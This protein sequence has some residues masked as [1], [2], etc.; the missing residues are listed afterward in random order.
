[1]DKI[2]RRWLAWQRVAYLV[3]NA[4]EW[5]GKKKDEELVV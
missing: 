5:L 2:P 1:M 4:V 3:Y